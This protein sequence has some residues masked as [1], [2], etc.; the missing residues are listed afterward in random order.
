LLVSSP[1]TWILLHFQTI[2]EFRWRDI[3]IC[4]LFSAFTS[5]PTS[6]LASKSVSVFSHMA[7]ILSPNKLTSSA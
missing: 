1:S 3:I 7:F 6:L 4:Y 5:R 2:H